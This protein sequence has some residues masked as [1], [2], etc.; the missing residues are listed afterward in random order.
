MKV[1][2][3]SI[4]NLTKIILILGLVV[5]P[6]Q[7]HFPPYDMTVDE[8]TALTRIVAGET[9]GCP[10][11]AKVA[12]AQV[13]ANRRKAGIEGGWFASDTPTSQDIVAVLIAQSVADRV[14][15]ATYFIGPGDLEKFTWPTVRTNFWQCKGTWVESR[16]DSN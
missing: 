12:A 2:L 5:G 10:F 3:K 13:A 15:G 11:D 7:F 14:F 9:R 1:R 6:A 16:K 8:M 4:L